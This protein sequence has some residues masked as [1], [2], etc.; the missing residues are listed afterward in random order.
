LAA[1]NLMGEFD[2]LWDSVLPEALDFERIGRELAEGIS[3]RRIE[4]ADSLYRETG[5][6]HSDCDELIQGALTYALGYADHP[7]TQLTGPSAPEFVGGGRQMSLVGVPFGT[8]AAILPHNAFLPLALA[9]MLN[10]LRAGNRVILRSPTQSARSAV[11]LSEVLSQIPEIAPFVSILLCSARPFVGAFMASPGSGL[12]QFFGSSR[13]AGELVARGFDSG[14]TV[15]VDG[16]GNTWAY[17]D[18]SFPP[19]AAAEILVA[20]AF[21]YRGQTCTSINGAILH[22][23]LFE[24]VSRRVAS[25]AREYGPGPLFDEAQAEWCLERVAGSRGELA[26]GGSR[27][28]SILA[29]TVVLNPAWESDLV[30]EGLFGP[31]LWLAPGDAETF[32]TRWLTNRY[33]LCAAILQSPPNPSFWARLPG[34]ARLVLNGDPSIEDPFEYWGGYAPSAQNPVSDWPAKYQRVVQVDQK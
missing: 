5:F 30:R 27:Q 22:P 34:L 15:L 11:L 2:D 28:G 16:E 32:A 18:E 24:S 19:E 4:F 23:D 8:V 26:V 31:A 14:K 13:R 17:V 1:G 20:G 21:R 33:P 10:A 29:P 12:L 25:L 6:A 9:C 7:S 3:R